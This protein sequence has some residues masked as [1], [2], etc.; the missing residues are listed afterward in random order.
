MPDEPERPLS[1]LRPGERVRAT[2]T[3][4]QLWGFI[5]KIHGYEPVG[6]SLDV[7]RRGSEPGVRQLAQNVLAVGSTIE[8]VVG[9]LRTW[10]HAPWIWVDLTSVPR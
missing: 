9:E 7:I 6:T 3:S 2:T 10:H 1:Q 8:L 4:H 5:A